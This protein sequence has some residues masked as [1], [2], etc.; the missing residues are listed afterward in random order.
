MEYALLLKDKAVAEIKLAYDWY[1]EQMDGLGERFLN[2]VKQNSELILSNPNRF[3]TTYK[4]FKEIYLREFPFVIIYFIDQTNAKIV[5]I[6]VFHC[7]RNPK[8]KFKK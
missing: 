3:K 2:I 5:I 8:L 6:S 4:N 7:S 1:E